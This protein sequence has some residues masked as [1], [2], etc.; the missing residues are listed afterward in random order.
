MNIVILGGPGAGKGTQATRVADRFKLRHISSGDLLRAE[1]ASQSPLGK[2]V[3]GILK[4]GKLVPDETILKLISEALAEEETTKRGGWIL[5][6][7]PR[8]ADQA[9]AFEDVLSRNRETVEAV[10]YLQVDTDILVSRLTNRGRADDTPE[11]VRKRL[12]VYD[13]EIKLLLGFYE[14]RYDVHQIDGSKSI[15]EVTDDIAGLV[16][17]YD[18]S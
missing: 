4:E 12:K 17:T 3:E 6:G 14:L 10:I 5:D 15:E 8:T 9:E 13:K 7:Y 18:L 2:Q 11:A 1:V 16:D